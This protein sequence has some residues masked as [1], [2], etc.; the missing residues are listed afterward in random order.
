ML[1]RKS[2]DFCNLIFTFRYS[3]IDKVSGLGLA[4]I[5]LEL[6]SQTIST[7]VVGDFDKLYYNK[8][9]V[10]LTV[11]YIP[12]AIS[13]FFLSDIVDLIDIEGDILDYSEEFLVTF[14]PGL[15]LL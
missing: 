5:I 9:Q 6:V 14:L 2:I 1:L 15:W 11:L 8:A 4:L 10:V 3:E 12:T 7:G 13:I